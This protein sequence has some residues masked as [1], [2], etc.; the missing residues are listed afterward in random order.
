MSLQELIRLS[1]L[2]V[3][4]DWQSF[5]VATLLQRVSMRLT[6]KR[7]GEDPCHGAVL[8]RSLNLWFKVGAIWL[9]QAF[10][11]RN[12]NLHT[13][14]SDS[15]R[16]IGVGTKNIFQSRTRQ[17]STSRQCDSSKAESS[18]PGW[19]ENLSIERHERIVGR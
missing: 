19:Q 11:V 9:L 12:R 3:Q 16:C 1:P 13:E 18:R 6:S 7:P 17:G 15:P 8:V 14:A 2:A 5:G 4:F 10:P